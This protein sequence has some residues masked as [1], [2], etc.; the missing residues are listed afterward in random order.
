VREVAAD[1]GVDE[2]RR[3]GGGVLCVLPTY[4]KL[5]SKRNLETSRKL[6]ADFQELPLPAVTGLVV[7]M[8]CFFGM[9]ILEARNC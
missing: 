7:A 5:Q 9:A 1:D 3:G 6:P 8:L 4:F 2:G